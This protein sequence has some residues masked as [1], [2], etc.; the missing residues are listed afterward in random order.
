MT[1]VLKISRWQNHLL[2]KKFYG[3]AKIE[4]HVF[5]FWCLMSNIR[6]HFYVRCKMLITWQ[7]TSSRRRWL[8]SHLD[9]LCLRKCLS[10]NISSHRFKLNH[11][12]RLSVVCHHKNDII[13]GSVSW[14]DFNRFLRSFLDPKIPL[15]KRSILIL[16]TPPL[17]VSGLR[18]VLVPPLEGVPPRGV[19]WPPPQ[20]YTPIFMSGPPWHSCTHASG[21]TYAQMGSGCKAHVFAHFSSPSKCAQSGVWD[22]IFGLNALKNDLKKGVKMTPVFGSKN[23]QKKTFFGP[24]LEPDKKDV[25]SSEKSSVL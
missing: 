13:F 5:Q 1:Y 15:K 16:F 25:S 12:N 4:N 21:Y 23:D 19:V 11:R 9:Y 3:I 22:P 2:H 14:P 10:T 18:G 6:F 8:N 20:K 24:S 17:T 7:N